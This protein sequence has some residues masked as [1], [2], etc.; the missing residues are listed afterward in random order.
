MTFQGDADGR[1]VVRL[2][3][4]FGY[5]TDLWLNVTEVSVD[6]GRITPGD[7]KTLILDHAPS[8][9]L[10]LRYRV[11]TGVRGRRGLGVEAGPA[12][13]AQGV[14]F[15]GETVIAYLEGRLDVPATV[16]LG[17]MPAG[18]T[19]ASD[20]EAASDTTLREARE[21][22]LLAGPTV[23]IVERRLPD[24]SRLRVALRGD[25]DFGD[26][27]VANNA[28]R[29]VAYQRQYWRAPPGS[30]LI[31]I[32]Q[33]PVPDVMIWGGQGRGADSAALYA[34]KAVWLSKFTEVLAHEI[35]HAWLA[36]ALGGLPAG[37]DEPKG[38][39]FS[40]GFAD[41]L[42]YR[43]LVKSGVFSPADFGTA[44]SGHAWPGPV[45]AERMTTDYWRDP[46][47]FNWPYFQ[48]F[49]LALRWDERLRGSGKGA[50]RDVLLAQAKHAAAGGSQTADALFPKVYAEVSGLDLSADIER[51]VTR[52]EPA[53]VP[54]AIARICDW[55]PTA[56]P[57][58]NGVVQLDMDGC[59]AAA[60]GPSI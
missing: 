30:F 13:G 47:L 35:T 37:T 14:S 54:E 2:P 23:R 15:L 33:V 4:R 58:R 45:S 56:D 59:V 19:L 50:L 25:F 43:S 20:L 29:L 44:L 46:E 16:R 40:E 36:R 6:G 49:N 34:S 51:Y 3:D 5:A 57:P 39:W 10:H 41:Y 22:Y 9:T 27:A 60:F 24:G 31:T 26:D 11:K 21:S 52:G 53:Q 42:G 1:T 48:G 12:E 8:A 55:L 17:A 38:Y 18:W 7:A 28:A 32:D